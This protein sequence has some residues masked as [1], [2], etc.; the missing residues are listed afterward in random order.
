MNLY[1]TDFPGMYLTEEGYYVDDYGNAYDENGTIIQE[2]FFGSVANK[3]GGLF[4]RKAPQ[5]SSY[6][7][8]QQSNLNKIKGFAAKSSN[9]VKNAG[10]GINNL[11]SSLAAKNAQM[12]KMAR[13]AEEF[14]LYETDMPGIYVTEDGYYVDSDGSLYDEDGDL[15]EEDAVAINELFGSSNNLNSYQQAHNNKITSMQHKNFA[16]G[17]IKQGVYGTTGMVG[18]AA[19]GGIAGRAIGSMKRFQGKGL[20]AK[21]AIVGGLAGSL[22]GAAKPTYQAMKNHISLQRRKY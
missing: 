8:K 16:K 13:M 5:V 1:Y 10:A 11:N 19:A 21:G 14:D 22:Y 12:L 2:G 7:A 6:V 3:I 18:G 20:G 15:I 9:T 4:K 17:L